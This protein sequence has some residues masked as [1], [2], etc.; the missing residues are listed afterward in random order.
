MSRKLL[1]AVCLLVLSSAV[2]A[3]TYT[4]GEAFGLPDGASLFDIN[5]SGQAAGLLM[6]ADG[7]SHAMRWSLQGDYVDLGQGY[8]VDINN[9]GQVLV[10]N[11]TSSFI[12]NLDG[13][14]LDLRSVIAG[15]IY[16]QRMNDLG[17]VAG[18][19]LYSAGRYRGFVWSMEAGTVVLPIPTGDATGFAMDVN[20]LGQ[21]VGYSLNSGQSY[22]RPFIW[23]SG[24]G[25]VALPSAPDATYSMP[26][27][28]NDV[29]QIIGSG[30]GYL[31]YR[32]VLWNPDGTVSD[33]GFGEAADLNNAGQVLMREYPGS[34]VLN[35]DGSRAEL[36]A[37]DGAMGIMAYGINDQG[38]VVGKSILNTG[39][40]RATIW[41]PLP[42]VQVV[43]I[44][45][46]IDVQPN[47][48]NLKSKGYVACFVEL[49]ADGPI[50]EDIEFDSLRLG[51]VAPARGEGGFGDYDGDG[52]P[53]LMVRFSRE[54]LRSVL[55][56]GSCLITLTGSFVNGDELT[57]EDTVKVIAGGK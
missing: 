27:R 42:D 16:P 44:T 3:T 21:V 53:D 43:V 12:S 1:L 50:V 20:N 15:Q 57:G 55:Q 41:E 30:S 4:I 52:I 37:P 8:G 7:R 35:P 32:S 9:A 28:L 10:Q 38:V 26:L 33:L 19:M 18:Y 31:G 25:L 14:I 48:I 49:P 2:C 45:A 36:P 23:S 56:P 51:G 39:V 34:Y 47:T 11:P 29:G 54:A 13:T 22:A 5:N 40:V 46:V 6:G 24:T 17:W